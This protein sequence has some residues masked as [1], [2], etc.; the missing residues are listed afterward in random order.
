M[1]KVGAYVSTSW[2][3]PKF[4]SVQKK[5]WMAEKIVVVTPKTALHKGYN[6]THGG[7]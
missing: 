1:E 6:G 3:S 5:C 7:I 2:M 4:K